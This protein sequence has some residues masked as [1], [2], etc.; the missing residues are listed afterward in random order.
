MRVDVGFGTC[1]EGHPLGRV[2]CCRRAL[3]L[4][5]LDRVD[6]LGDQL[7]G[8]Q[9]LLTRLGQGIEVGGAKAHVPAPAVH[10]KPVQPHSGF[11]R[12]HPQIKSA[13]VSVEARPL[14]LNLSRRQSGCFLW[15]VSA[16]FG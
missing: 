16:Q 11:G 10:L 1:P 14:R 12:R 4:A 5:C 13:T 7:A 6:T 8:F 9:R 3:R 15:Q 2:N